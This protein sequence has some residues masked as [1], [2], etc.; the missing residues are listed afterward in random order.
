M[1][2]IPCLD[3][4]T[5]NN[6]SL[7]ER[8]LPVLGKM[9]VEVGS[10]VA[11]FTDLGQCALEDKRRFDL[12][13]GVWG[14]VTSVTQE[15]SVL[16]ETQTLDI[17]LPFFVGDYCE[18]EL[19][20]FPNPD[21][22]LQLNYFTHYVKD[23]FGKIVYVG[24]LIDVPTCEKAIEMG[25]GAL[26]AGG[27]T[28]EAYRFAKTKGLSVGIF[29]G[30]GNTVSTPEVI[31]EILKKYSGR[32]VFIFG[33]PSTADGFLKIPVEKK[34]SDVEMKSTN[35]KPYFEKLKK[36]LRVLVLQEPYLG[37]VGLVSKVDAD[38]VE[39]KFSGETEIISQVDVSNIL[40]L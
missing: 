23:F 31:Y 8:C 12:F 24:A 28:S 19:L 34:F 30:F 16:I 39:I 14:S 2:F 10:S 38:T 13:S 35:E 7:I 1:K 9:Q 22:N 25:V 29:V 18:G 21:K 5:N 26:L 20:V 3:A 36:G 4:Y 27:I 32:Y 11:P 17:N 15:K 37:K 40:A 6:K 33:S